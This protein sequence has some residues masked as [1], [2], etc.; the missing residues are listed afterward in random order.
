MGT[1]THKN[2]YLE[3]LLFLGLSEGGGWVGGWL[4]SGKDFLNLTSVTM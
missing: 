4:E 3:K 2:I 1:P